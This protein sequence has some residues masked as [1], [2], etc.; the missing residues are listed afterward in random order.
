MPVRIRSSASG[1]T[2]GQALREFHAQSV[3]A[4]EAG[5][6][7][8]RE[9]VV[10]E[11]RQEI[12]RAFPDSRRLPTT[13]TATLF[14]TREDGRPPVVWVHPRK[15]SNA[16]EILGS[17]R[18]G[19]LVPTKSGTAMAIPTGRVPRIRRGRRM[20]PDEVSRHFG[21][22]LTLVPASAFGGG[23]GKAWG[24]LV[25]RRQTIG[26]SGRVR[27]ATAG[28]ARQGR[29]EQLIVMFILV[30]AVTMPAR[31]APE[32]IVQSWADLAPRQIDEAARRIGL[33]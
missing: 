20:T 21:E 14:P 18:G 27:A 17:H 19:D 31:L 29:K 13:I 28:R 3:Q 25:L 32:R 4:V 24:Y 8:V 33:R 30:P 22:R 12:Q 6:A 1:A 9:G 10:T 23:N 2:P 15:G 16:A 5:L 11:L 7:G 26:R